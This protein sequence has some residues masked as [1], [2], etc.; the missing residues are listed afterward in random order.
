MI[1]LLDDDIMVSLGCISQVGRYSD[2]RVYGPA[3]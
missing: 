1:G 2:I 3:A